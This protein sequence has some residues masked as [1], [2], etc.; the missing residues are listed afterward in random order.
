MTILPAGNS[1]V[2]G[3]GDYR[4]RSETERKRVPGLLVQS[5]RIGSVSA[6][7]RPVTLDDVRG[8]P[9]PT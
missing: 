7:R 8:W 1:C 3:H 2:N 9:K 4:L 6:R 5:Q